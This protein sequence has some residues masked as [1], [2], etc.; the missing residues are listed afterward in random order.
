MITN[1]KKSSRTLELVIS[2]CKVCY[3]M[4]DRLPLGW[5]GLCISFRSTLW[6]DIWHLIQGTRV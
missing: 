1:C 3:S 5:Y 4:I 6:A 2:R